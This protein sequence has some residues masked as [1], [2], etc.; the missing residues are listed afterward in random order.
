[1]AYRSTAGPAYD[2]EV[3]AYQRGAYKTLA[4]PI[5]VGIQGMP[6]PDIQNRH[7]EAAQVMQCAGFHTTNPLPYERF[8]GPFRRH[9]HEPLPLSVNETVFE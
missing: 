5:P 2:L 3:F 7:T 9:V 8:H 4:P 6:I 1:M